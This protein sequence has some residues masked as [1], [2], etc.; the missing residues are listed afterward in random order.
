MIAI[1]DSGSSKTHWVF[2]SGS[3]TI[4]IETL[5]INPF[6]QETD[7]IISG[8]KSS[9]PENL[10]N[11]FKKVYFYGADC[12]KGKTG[13]TVAYA[14]ISGFSSTKVQVEDDMTGTA[15]SLLDSNQ[16]IACILGTGANS[17]FYNGKEISDKIPTL[18]FIL[19]DEGSSAHL[20]ELFLND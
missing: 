17:C 16:G 8:I 6:F 1:A 12:I 10:S 3:E 5:G 4:A 19:G 7:Q 2:I 15:K 13:K 18:G 11:T 20:G 14:F 9:I